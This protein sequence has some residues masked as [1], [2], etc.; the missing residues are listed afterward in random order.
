ML[1][2]ASSSQPQHWPGLAHTGIS[3]KVRPSEWGDKITTVAANNWPLCVLALQ[4]ERY[5]TLTA[6]TSLLD[7]HCAFHCVSERAVDSVLLPGLDT[8][9]D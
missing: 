9:P 3:R 6:S 8:F 7:K 4:P 2:A 5:A 1:E